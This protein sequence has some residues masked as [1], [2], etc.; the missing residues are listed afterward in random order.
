MMELLDGL[1]LKKTDIKTDDFKNKLITLLQEIQKQFNNCDAEICHNEKK[2]G[3]QRSL[4]L[5]YKT[6]YEK[7][8][9]EN[10]YLKKALH[11]LQ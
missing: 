9:K 4:I 1:L 8:E 5:F 3:K 7:M 6:N 2:C 10:Y 11:Q